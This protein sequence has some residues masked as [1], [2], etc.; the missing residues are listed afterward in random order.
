MNFSETPPFRSGI[1][2][3]NPWESLL[4]Q[5]RLCSDI[6]LDITVVDMYHMVSVEPSSSCARLNKNVIST[7]G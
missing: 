1:S 5:T 6:E 3:E 2:Q 7:W 4:E